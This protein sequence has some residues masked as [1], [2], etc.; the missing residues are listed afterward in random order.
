[1][2]DG[3]AVGEEEVAKRS[4]IPRNE[5]EDI[6]HSE[7]I[8]RISAHSQTSGNILLGLHFANETDQVHVDN[9][10]F[11]VAILLGVFVSSSSITFC[12]SAARNPP[13]QLDCVTILNDLMTIDVTSAV[14]VG[15]GFLCTLIF[16]KS[17]A[18]AH[19]YQHLFL[20]F[21]IDLWIATIL[22]CFCG[23]LYNMN[24]GRFSFGD[25]GLTLL[26]GLLSIRQ[27]EYNQSPAYF[28]TLNTFAWP[29][30]CV[31]VSAFLLPRTYQGVVYLHVKFQ[32]FGIYVIVL[33]CC[34]GILLFTIF[35]SLN[36][37]TNIFYSNASNISYRSL[38]F[39]LGVNL[40]YLLQ[41]DNAATLSIMEI[42]ARGKYVIIIVFLCIW[43]SEL[44]VSLNANYKTECVRLYWFNSCLTDHHGILLRGCILGVFMIAWSRQDVLIQT[45]IGSLQALTSSC[46]TV[47]LCAPVFYIMKGLLELT[48]TQTMIT[49]NASL[50][51]FLMPFT[52][53]GSVH[54]YSLY[55]K[56]TVQ[57]EVYVLLTMCHTK[58]KSRV[59]NVMEYAL[60]RTQTVV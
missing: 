12:S 7:A 36:D 53:L 34:G 52:A 46:S 60:G 17:D 45:H 40:Y 33:V 43:W 47:L 57:T 1:M 59:Q 54:L 51:S 37:H 39:N 56:P 14:T 22:C 35:S 58:I 9:L 30:Q 5:A 3:S 28:H 2:L 16:V 29:L 25:L 38:E 44:D 6:I 27:L 50:I 20:S 41:V 11:V 19:E 49:Q 8:E 4:L 31:I 32:D 13:T 24:H 26:E 23:V 10:A 18:T 42:C 55:I 48:F 21:L 15:L